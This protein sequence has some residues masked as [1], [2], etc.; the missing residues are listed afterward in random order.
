MRISRVLTLEEYL[1]LEHFCKVTEDYQPLDNRIFTP[2]MAWYMPWI[3]DPTGEREKLG[4]PVMHNHRSKNIGRID[5]LSSNYWTDWAG[6]R[7]PIAIVCPGGS[8]YEPDRNLLNKLSQIVIGN[9]P[10]IT[11]LPG[12]VTTTYHG[13]LHEGEFGSN[14]QVYLKDLNKAAK[15]EQA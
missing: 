12:I 9:L 11:V 4:L 1:E 14:Y 13:V 3:Y 10:R 6:I 5:Y 8:I 15:E 2:G 7:S